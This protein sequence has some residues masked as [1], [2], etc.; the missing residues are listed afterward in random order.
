MIDIIPHYFK[1]SHAYVTQ[2]WNIHLINVQ[3]VIVQYYLFTEYNEHIKCTSILGVDF[4]FILFYLH[5]DSPYS[6]C[7]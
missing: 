2:F 1:M 7:L 4:W 3:Y 5:L 6:F